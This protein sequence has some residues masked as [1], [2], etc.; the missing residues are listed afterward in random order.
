MT[1]VR[2]FGA[3]L[4]AAVLFVAGAC[5]GEAETGPPAAQVA[6]KVEVTVDSAD[7]PR[8]FHVELAR[9]AGEQERGL[10]FRTNLP[11]DGGM[12]FAPYPA[13]GP[14][15]E[16]RFW[17]KNTPSALDILFIRA[18]GTIARVAENAVPFSEENIRSGEAVA[19]VLEINAGLAAKLGIRSG[20]KV[21]W[22][23]Q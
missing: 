19:A 17:M 22:P 14:P 18:D 13:D 12:L 23:K 7:G 1:R 10:M 3:A 15:R 2:G 8:V 21:R 5:Q 9:T 6:Q 11:Q 16:A 20:D 4:A